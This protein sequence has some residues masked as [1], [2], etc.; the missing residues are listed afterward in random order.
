MVDAVKSGQLAGIYCVNWQKHAAKRAERLGK[1]WWTAIPK[2]EDAVLMLDPDD[3]AN[4]PPLIAFRREF[5][6]S[7][8]GCGRL[9]N[10][11]VVT[12]SPGRLD[13]ALIRGVE[14][15]FAFPRP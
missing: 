6:P 14:C 3:L 4:G 11:T 13:A 2:G 12:A 5:G 8:P 7:G 1:T 15:L 10:D 9:K